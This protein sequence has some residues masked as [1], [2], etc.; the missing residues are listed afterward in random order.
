MFLLL[1][2]TCST[3]Q[4]QQTTIEW[5]QF[6]TNPDIKPTIEAM[7]ADFEQ[8]NPD[9]EV[10]LTDL[11][12][13][14]GHEKIVI[15]LA[16]GTGP[17]IL[18]LGSDWIAQ[19]ADAG[20]LADI[21]E[22]VSDQTD[23]FQGWEMSTWKNRVYAKPWIL[24]TRVLFINTDIT[25]QTVFSDKFV[26][27]VWRHL[28]YIRDTLAVRFPDK[29]V[30][31]SNAPEKH[32]LYKKFLPFLWGSRGQ[33]F[34]E[35]NEYCVISSMYALFG[36]EAYEYT[37]SL[38]SYVS[39]QRGIEDA[40]LQSKVSFIL[41]GDWFLKRIRKEKP[42]LGFNTAL[43]PLV[44]SPKMGGDG[45][46][47]SFLGGEFL[48][49]TEASKHKE[50]A[51]KL[52]DFITSPESQVRFCKA[53]GSACPSSMIAREDEYFA[54]DPHLQTFI[55]QLKFAKAPPVDPHWVHI[56]A[57]IEEAVEAAVFGDKTVAE[58][59]RE[60]QH[61]ITEIRRRR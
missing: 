49:V 4:T 36:L 38:G 5:W 52:I 21:T 16:S 14:N 3:A 27:K 17:D 51:I 8:E 39:S 47:Y 43:V 20:Q 26:P 2:A 60:A 32:R 40:F 54:S 13:A 33:I 45:V 6:W 7:V 53:S 25:G 56:E 59:L 1:L 44:L 23:V 19:F 48:A 15:A 34:T 30:W 28:G 58:A 37:H 22:H 24:G 9:I 29:Y 61:K 31:G 10:K 42:D 18:E 50:A 35:G 41:S 12:W 11:T 55:E 46:N 57:A